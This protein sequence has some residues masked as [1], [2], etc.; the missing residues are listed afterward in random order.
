MHAGSTL[1]SEIDSG[2]DLACGCRWGLAGPTSAGPGLCAAVTA[3][4]LSVQHAH[5]LNSLVD[6]AVTSVCACASE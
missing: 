2:I 4:D 1:G 3:G 5:R 6:D